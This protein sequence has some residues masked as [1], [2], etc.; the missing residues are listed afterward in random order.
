MIA[1]IETGSPKVVGFRLCGKLHDEDYKQFVP[2]METILTAEVRIV[3]LGIL[4]CHLVGVKRSILGIQQAFHRRF[5][6]QQVPALDM[7]HI[8][9]LPTLDPFLGLRCQFIQFPK[10]GFCL[11]RG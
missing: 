4:P 6:H 5:H 11:F 1:T 2:R 7:P 8:A 10:F 9:P 3:S